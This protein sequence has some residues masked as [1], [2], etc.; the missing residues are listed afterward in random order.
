MTRPPPSGPLRSVEPR[1]SLLRL[2]H[3]VYL[4]APYREPCFPAVTLRVE[5]CSLQIVPV[6]SR[7]FWK[8]QVY[9]KE[10]Y[11][12]QMTKHM[13]GSRYRA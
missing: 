4:D 6:V 10:W 3:S 8:K 5:C 2:L 13:R 9:G 12:D 7:M 11:A 1:G